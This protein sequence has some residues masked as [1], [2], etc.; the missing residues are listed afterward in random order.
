MK[1]STP[2]V[3]PHVDAP[4]AAVA[5]SSSQKYSSR[6]AI[7]ELRRTSDGRPRPRLPVPAYAALANLPLVPLNAS[8]RGRRRLQA[9]EVPLGRHAPS[10]ST[11]Q[12][13][14]R[15]STQRLKTLEE[16]IATAGVTSALNVTRENPRP[17]RLGR[18]EGRGAIFLRRTT[19][20]HAIVLQP[21]MIKRSTPASSPRFGRGSRTPRMHPAQLSGGGGD[22]LEAGTRPTGAPPPLVL[23]QGTRS[24]SIVYGVELDATCRAVKSELRVNMSEE[25]RYDIRGGESARA[26][27]RNLRT[28]AGTGRRAEVPRTSARM[29]GV[30]EATSAAR[31]LYRGRSGCA[32]ACESARTL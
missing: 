17:A 4:D 23:Q 22:A 10:P 8:C 16:I 15:R 11:R 9:R 26:R 32:R 12:A 18:G 5:A 29:P 3:A 19:R 6:S 27:P 14:M 25:R 24:K 7:F 28:P 20:R 2:G 13:D 21:R 1:S 30:T 31:R